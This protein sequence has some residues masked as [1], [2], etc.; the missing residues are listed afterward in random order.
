MAVGQIDHHGPGFSAR[1]WRRQ[2][3]GSHSDTFR[4]ARG[5][6]TPGARATSGRVSR[7]RM[8]SPGAPSGSGRGEK[9]PASDAAD[10]SDLFK[11][12]G[13][14]SIR[15]SA[16]PRVDAGGRPAGDA[17]GAGD[18]GSR[19]RRPRADAD[20]EDGDGAPE[21]AGVRP[22]GSRARADDADGGSLRSRPRLLSK[23]RALCGALARRLSAHAD[24]I[25]VAVWRAELGVAEVLR[26]RGK[27]LTRMG[28]QVGTR[29]F[30]FPEETAF[31]VETERCA[32]LASAESAVPL[33][34]R[35]VRALCVGT[36]RAS[37]TSKTDEN[38]ALT[39]SGDAY[40]LYAHLARRGYV[41]RRFGAP[42]SADAR[43]W[44]SFFAKRETNETNETTETMSNTTE[45]IETSNRAGSVSNT[46]V[47]AKA[48][49]AGGDARILDP[50]RVSA[51]KTHAR[52]GPWYLSARRWLDATNE[53]DVLKRRSSPNASAGEP[54]SEGTGP[55]P[56][57]D[58]GITCLSKRD[59][60][61][62]DTI[63][64]RAT[65]VSV[66]PNK[67]RLKRRT[68]LPSPAFRAYAP[69]G[70]FS[71]KNP[72]PVACVA[73]LAEA[74]RAPSIRAAAE[75]AL[76][77]RMRDYSEL[78]FQESL[79]GKIAWASVDGGV[80]VTHGFE[81]VYVVDPDE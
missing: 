60:S 27:H 14:K 47:F 71:R 8:D 61:S 58:I 50:T 19:A 24:N 51:E 20:A 21:S 68:T 6:R 59:R 34:L 79:E 37:K 52:V 39:V 7:S 56:D 62:I 30:L 18:D 9:R 72:G 69:N 36:V 3:P 2:A 28:Y 53:K 35:A 76:E 22:G 32:L 10:A 75:A 11:R 64:S 4:A 67:L 44:R 70:N 74:A 33:S 12:G 65:N 45:T 16:A 25:T 23:F 40:A 31:L 5:W 13:P 66:S 57:P 48:A 15:A 80:V 55:D 43:F 17:E 1:L 26:P 77:M 29:A 73:F 81:T 54:P 41:V 49:K 42:W 63:A 46:R 78:G 38:N